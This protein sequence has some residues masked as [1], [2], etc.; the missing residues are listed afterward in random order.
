[1]LSLNGSRKRLCD[2]ITRREL[3]R[4]GGLGAVG[5]G[6][7]GLLEG[8]ATAASSTAHL[9]GFGKAKRCFTSTV[10]PAS[11]KRST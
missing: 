3:L 7:H 6:L 9:P 11:S 2:G 10:P 8:E 4:I 5:L 1:M